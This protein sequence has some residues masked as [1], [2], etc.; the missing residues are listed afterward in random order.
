MTI[1]NLGNGAY[2]GLSTDVKP[3]KAE[4]NTIR[5]TDTGDIHISD[6]T[7]W[8]LQ[9]QGP[10]SYRRWGRPPGGTS[11]TGG[12]G[13]MFA[14]AA[15]ATAGTQGFT[16]DATN[17]RYQ[18]LLTG[19]AAT[20]KG[21][22]RLSLSSMFMRQWNPRIW[23]RFALTDTTLFNVYLGMAFPNELTGT[24]P[25][26][27][28]NGAVFGIL[29]GTNNFVF[30]SNDGS[31]ATIQEDAVTATAKDALIHEV[32][33][34]CD[35]PNSR[36]AYKFDNAAYQFK[37]TAA[38]I[39]TATG[40]MSVVMSSETTTGAAKALKLYNCYVQSDK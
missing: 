21:G 37:N 28:I 19:V 4:G 29:D 16:A 9:S 35:E 40:A 8:W 26:N 15:A 31:G 27:A 2:E 36:I 33:I 11:S 6:G 30:L 34:V 32:K 17:G 5:E 7:F 12:T 24:D 25:L 3:T 22:W 23:F 10:R 20:N 14:V 39:P 38:N 1:E 18:T 13:M